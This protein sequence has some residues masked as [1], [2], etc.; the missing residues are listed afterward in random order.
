MRPLLCLCLAYL[1]PLA[2]FSYIAD[3]KRPFLVSLYLIFATFCIVG[4]L[5]YKFIRRLPFSKSL[6]LIIFCII[7]SSIAVLQTIFMF[8]FKY[9]TLQEF[10]MKNAR[11]T[12]YVTKLHSE[13]SEYASFIAQVTKADGKA[14]DFCISVFTSF[15]PQISEGDIFVCDALLEPAETSLYY[16]ENMLKRQN[17]I[18]TADIASAENFEITGKHKTLLTYFGQTGDELG[19]KFD[20]TFSRS[21]ASLAKALLLG[22]RYELSDIT[23]RNFRRIGISHIL[24]LSGTHLV[25]IVGFIMYFLKF[26]IRSDKLR[27]ICIALI[28]LFTMLITGASPSIMRAG[29]MLIYCQAGYLLRRRSD[30]MTAL[31]AVTTLIVLSDPLK[32]LDAG[33]T[34]S[35]AATF[36]I[37]LFSDILRGTSLKLFGNPF[38]S[39]IPVKLLRYCFE[40]L[41]ISFFA[42]VFVTLAAVFIFDCVSLVSA[43][44]TLV[45]T[46]LIV[47]FMISSAMT[48]LLGFLPTL[49]QV[50]LS[51]SELLCEWISNLSSYFSDKDFVCISTGYTVVKPLAIIFILVF[52]YFVIKDAQ[53]KHFAT[54]SLLFS[55]ICV[56]CIALCIAK[57]LSETHLCVISSEKDDGIVISNSQNNVYIDI[58]GGSSASSASVASAVTG[59]RGTD[60]DVYMLTHYH[61][62]HISA[63]RKINGRLVIRKLIL[64]V[65]SNDTDKI[66]AADLEETAKA[67]GIDYEYYEADTPL[68]VNGVCVTAYN[69]DR[70]SGSSHVR[71]ALSIEEAGEVFVYSAGYNEKCESFKLYSDVLRKADFVLKGNHGPKTNDT[72]ILS[73]LTSAYCK[74]I[75]YPNALEESK[76]L[77]R[78]TILPY[79]YH[80]IT[81][82]SD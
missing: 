75:V 41:C 47:A 26:L 9:R 5:A 43:I 2:V 46:P 72:L 7:I 12:A 61:F 82:F 27:F 30:L 24:A 70:V 10:E 81:S 34:L 35:F 53:V 44:S 33:L 77:L 67:L 13:Q 40:S 63:L 39:N 71:I 1:A 25:L 15:S 64:P 45:L 36:G 79:G 76:V 68:N 20:R 74:L 21:T 65:P 57:D 4:V 62:D 17:I 55:L 11:I 3:G 58:S 38:D 60:I 42:S 32:I 54:F 29:L 80:E 51:L 16:N 73:A 49:S 18:F 19:Y 59:Y 66:Y 6:I 14:V 48:L 31:F 28:A 56:L 50:F 78:Q 69:P 52:L 23:E 22:D 8:S 37:A